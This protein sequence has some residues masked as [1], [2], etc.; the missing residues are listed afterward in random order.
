MKPPL[1]AFCQ[2]WLIN[3]LAVLVAANVVNGLH[4]DNLMGL[5][6][7]SLILGILNSCLR[8]LLLLFSLPLLIAT[9]GL[10]TLVINAALLY[11]VGW[12]VKPFHV[13]SFG[14][15]FWGALV[16]SLISLFASWLTGASQIQTR[17]RHR[18]S[19]P[20]RRGPPDGSGPVIDV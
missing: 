13:D 4:Y 9:L 12:L 3:T 5:L 14:A 2:R 20:P 10:F 17:L 16:I 19:S 6:L 8:P 18:R 11:F 7:A 1:K 15:A